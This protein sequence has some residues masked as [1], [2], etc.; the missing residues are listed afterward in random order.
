MRKE[1]QDMV[2]KLAGA[3]AKEAQ[4]IVDGQLTRLQN[5]YNKYINEANDRLKRGEMEGIKDH[6]EITAQRIR[7]EQELGQVED[8]KNRYRRPNGGGT[9]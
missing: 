7:L 5:D 4:G 8:L 6:T 9:H 1:Y 2:D 3:T